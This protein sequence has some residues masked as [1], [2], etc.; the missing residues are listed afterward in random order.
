MKHS[1]ARSSVELLSMWEASTTAPCNQSD[2]S[3][4]QLVAAAK[5]TLALLTYQRAYLQ[6]K[7]NQ[8]D[9][10]LEEKSHVEKQF[11]ARK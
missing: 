10:I 3:H 6:R 4:L 11:K 1:G 5:E 8:S 7:I 2:C 9:R